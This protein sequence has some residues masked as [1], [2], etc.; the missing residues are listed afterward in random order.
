MGLE[1]YKARVEDL[2]VVDSIF[3]VVGLLDVE[4]QEGF[5]QH[6]G[7]LSKKKSKDKKAE[8]NTLV[9]QTGLLNHW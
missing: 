1:F 8:R 3:T 9:F 5:W 7:I 6:G 2:E 4:P